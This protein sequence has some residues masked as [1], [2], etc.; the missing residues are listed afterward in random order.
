[1]INS[2]CG[3]KAPA[4]KKRLRRKSA[5]GQKKACGQQKLSSGSITAANTL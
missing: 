3:E 2:A 5:C 4:A 1:L